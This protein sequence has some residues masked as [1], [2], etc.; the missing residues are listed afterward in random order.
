VLHAAR[1][2]ELLVNVQVIGDPGI[3][4]PEVAHAIAAVVGAAIGASAYLVM[5]TVLAAGDD[6]ELHLTFSEPLRIP[7]PD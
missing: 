4:E 5:L 2:R 7:G 6:A 3:L 1:A